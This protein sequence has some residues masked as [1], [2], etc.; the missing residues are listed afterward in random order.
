MAKKCVV[1][2]K[3]LVSGRAARVKEDF[4]INGIRKVKKALRVARGNELYVCE[5]DYEKQQAR[6]KDY[7]KNIVIFATIGVVIFAMLNVLPLIGGRLEISFFLSTFFLS[8]L[9]VIVP[10]VFKY[11]PASEG[12]HSL[13]GRSVKKADRGKK[14]KR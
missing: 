13:A 5:N 8:A 11:V 9:I 4:V 7:E 12:L 2:Q 6:R 1:C 14:S 3:D 10:V